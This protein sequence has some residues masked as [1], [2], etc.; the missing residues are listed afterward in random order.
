MGRTGYLG[1]F[2]GPSRDTQLGKLMGIGS[3]NTQQ[4][5]YTGIIIGSVYRSLHGYRIARKHM[6]SL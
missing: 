6:K 5:G 4:L 3:I 1:M 2:M